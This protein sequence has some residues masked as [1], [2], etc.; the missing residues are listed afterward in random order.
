[1]TVSDCPSTAT[2]VPEN[3][4]GLSVEWSMVQHWFGTSRASVVQPTVALLQSLTDAPGGGGVLRIGGNS[5]DGY[6]WNPKANFR[7]NTLFTG[8][9]TPGMIDA[10]LEAS[11]RSGW[12]ITLGLNLA[13]GSRTQAAA[14]THYAVAHDPTHQLLAVEIGNEPTTYFGSD[15]DAY[16]GRVSSYVDALQADPVTRNVQFTGPAL[17]NRTDLGFLTRMRQSFGSGLPFLTW[18]HYA[19]RP[20]L[21][22]LLSQAVSTDWID[23][24]AQVQQAAGGTPTRMDEGNSVGNGGL[25]RVSNVT[26]STAWLADA[27]LTGAQ[28]GLAGYNAHAWDA[29]YYPAENRTAYYTPFVVRGGLVT[30]RPEFYAL[31]LLKNIAGKQFC[32]AT[33][34]VSAGRSVKSWTLHDPA[35]GHLLVYVVEKDAGSGPVTVVA[36]ASYTGGAV[37]SR[38]SDPNGCGGRDTNIQGATLPTQGRFNWTPSAVHQVGE[39]PTYAMALTACQTALI[40]ISPTAVATTSY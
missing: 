10:L 19:N 32:Q 6:V 26:G 3:Y 2:Q 5:Q 7:A 36:P 29:Y 25:N 28:S 21:T 39:A 20:T 15:A 24:L 4:V 23:R 27:M 13:D 18:H 22:G 33:T 14:L 34:V 38:I 8:S 37:V 12:K 35:T 31:A 16:M 11:R 17:S 30:P 1:M 40:D 9:I